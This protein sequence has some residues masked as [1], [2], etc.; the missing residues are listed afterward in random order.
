MK[1]V[2]T[3]MIV[4]L[5][6]LFAGAFAIAQNGD[7]KPAGPKGEAPH[8]GPGKGGGP[9]AMLDNLL[10]PPLL[11]DLKLTAEQKTKYD[12]LQAAFK[13]E[14]DAWKAAHPNAAEQLRTARENKDR[15]AMQKLAE[16]RKPVMEA[17]KANVDKLRE[18]LTAEQK[19]TLDKGM[20][21]ARNRRG[22]GGPGGPGGG[23]GGDGPKG[24]HPPKPAA[25]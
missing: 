1:S 12:G 2:R 10:P 11:D 25:D 13:K 3:M 4:A 7:T 14:L 8:G 17:R 22:P 15:E 16:E 19:A 5:A 20:E 23:P 18:S 21:Q 9:G 6:V 24:D